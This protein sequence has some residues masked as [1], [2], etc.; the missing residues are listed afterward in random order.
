MGARP[1]S[2]VPRPQKHPDMVKNRRI[3]PSEGRLSPSEEVL[4]RSRLWDLRRFRF[5]RNAAARRSARLSAGRPGDVSALPGAS[6]SAISRLQTFQLRRPGHCG[7]FAAAP[8]CRHS[9]VVERT[10]GKGEVLSS[11]LSGGTSFSQDSWAFRTALSMPSD[12]SRRNGARM[13]AQMRTKSAQ[14]VLDRFASRLLAARG[15]SAAREI[16]ASVPN[17]S[18][19]QALDDAGATTRPARQALL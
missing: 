1:Q 16:L 10:L 4:E 19:T 8:Q 3:Q 12:V 7:R 2:L 6:F 14:D 9:S 13:C 18:I 17:A 15:N 11:I 5:A